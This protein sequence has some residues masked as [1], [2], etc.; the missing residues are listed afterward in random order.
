VIHQHGI[1]QCIR[2]VERLRLGQRPKV[3]PSC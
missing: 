3:Q 2:D 1:H